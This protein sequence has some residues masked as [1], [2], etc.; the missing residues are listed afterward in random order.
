[1]HELSASYESNAKATLC[2]TVPPRESGPG[3]AGM[4]GGP[5]G[6][7]GEGDA[8]SWERAVLSFV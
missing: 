3:L 8:V 5:Y 7:G 6:M 4:C 1:M 2:S